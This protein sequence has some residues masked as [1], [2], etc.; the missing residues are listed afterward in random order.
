MRKSFALLRRACVPVVGLSLLAAGLSISA[1]EADTEPPAAPAENTGS[2]AA[3]VAQAEATSTDV[4]VEDATTPTLLTVAHPDGTLTSTVDTDPV[5]MK[6]E[7][8]WTDIST[9]LIRT[10]VNGVSVL[11]PEN[12]PVDI[13]V[14]TGGSDKIASLDDRK[15]H[16]LTQ[17]WPFGTLP[18][19]FV[20]G[21]SATFRQVLPGVDLIQ[22]AHKTGISQVLKIETAEAARDPRVSEMRIFLDSRNAV[23]EQQADGS[24][25]AKGSDSGEVALRNTGGL[26]WDSSV[27]G[28]TATDPGGQGVARPFSLTLGTEDGKQS[29][30][31]G[32]D[33]ILDTA[34]L[35]FPVYVDPDWTI[36]RAN[37]IFVD[38]AY[39]ETSYWNGNLT[40]GQVH[41]GF[42]PNYWAPDGVN[43]LARSY[44]QFDSSYFVG[45][46]ILQAKL[47]T[48]ETWSSSCTPAN[49]ASW[50]TDPVY[51]TTRWNAQPVLRMRTDMGAV[52]KGY[53]ASCPA[54]TVG[55]DLMAGKSL[56]LNKSVWTIM[57]AAG[58]E[59]DPLGWKK[60]QNSAT[61]TVTHNSPPNTPVITT[62]S[63]GKWAG[64]PWD[65]AHGAYYVTRN[66]Q[67]TFQV[68]DSD[69]DGAQGGPIYVYMEVY[70]KA[71]ALVRGSG[72][73][74]GAAAGD[75]FP[76]TI[77]VSLPDGEYYLQSQSR[78]GWNA[79]SG[80]MKFNFKVDTTPPAAPEVSEIDLPNNPAKLTTGATHADNDGVIGET[81]YDFHLQLPA[82]SDPAEG[83]VF[84]ITSGAWPASS[85]PQS[86]R[87]GDP[88]IQE[89][90]AVCPAGGM[91]ADIRIAALDETTVL[92][93]WAFDS[94]GNV[95]SVPL[96]NATGTSYSFTVGAGSVRPT[97]F[98]PLTL[99]GQT[100]WVT[101][102]PGTANTCGQ[103]P[104]GD[105]GATPQILTFPNG[106]STAQTS[107][108][109]IDPSN[110]FSVSGWFCPTS[111]TGTT[112]QDLIVQWTSTGPA[113]A[114]RAR[115]DGKPELVAWA[116]VSGTETVI[117]QDLVS[118]RWAYVSAIYDKINA[119]LRITKTDTNGSGTWIKA[120]SPVSHKTAAPSDPVKLG[121]SFIG[122]IYKPL[123]TQGVLKPGTFK[124]ANQYSFTNTSKGLLK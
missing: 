45:K 29:Q 77:D 102:Q 14:G 121:S 54:G 97:T 37:Y 70:T 56:L 39:P 47:N 57:L 99:N 95:S 89:Y 82:G 26:W 118:G 94:A 69:P 9:D 75:Q 96:H 62:I 46:D 120:A 68:S 31:F 114:L 112:V 98:A 58:N 83:F 8:G 1:A 115:T 53:N 30:I 36:T 16:S 25:T 38:N 5:R 20:E 10:T 109:V 104:F 110:S 34:N 107:G 117:G 80:T 48:V 123:L 122:N 73:I 27:E 116:S 44:Y 86:I 66:N 43:H 23:V 63:G 18:E 41:V 103:I 6:T 3:A 24:L 11:K 93:V 42:L 7:A 105:L 55:F 19:P 84:S 13:T 85:Y 124:D 87:C 4:V 90:V 92:T 101:P 12:V 108:Q 119:Q 61:I 88:R 2:E 81:I 28:A 100:Q 32:M 76:W 51:S 91:S 111:A 74:S 78:D 65:Y 106:T 17:S 22:L 21:N 67:P 113:A 15:G 64:T 35:T 60:F 71:G 50:I 72:A 79:Y 49:V 33:Q 40:D 52:A 59:S